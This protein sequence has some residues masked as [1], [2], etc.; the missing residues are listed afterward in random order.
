MNLNKGIEKKG[1]IGGDYFSLYYSRPTKTKL[2][3]YLTQFN[4]DDYYCIKAVENQRLVTYQ[5][6]IEFKHCTYLFLRKSKY[7]IDH[8]NLWVDWLIETAK[9]KFLNKPFPPFNPNKIIIK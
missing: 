4:F 8:I 6:L 2:D 3:H 1:I 7:D 9:V 5:Q